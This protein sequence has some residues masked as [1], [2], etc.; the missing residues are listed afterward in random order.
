ML[1]TA[2][3]LVAILAILA[4]AVVYGVD[5][6]AAVMNRAVYTHLDDRTVT[7]VAGWGHYYGDK[8]MPIFGVSGVVTAVLTAVLA[9]LAGHTGAAVAA[10]I[11]VAALVI[12]LAIYVRV[13]KPVN[14]AQTAAAQSGD[15]PPNARALQEKWDSVITVRVA[16]QVVAIT[17]LAAT[18]ALI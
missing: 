12:W 6:G 8:R 15:I 18:V 2:T 3:Q 11:A 10:G 5:T 1:S 14:T 16:L 4:N 17:G 9:A 7:M 13:A